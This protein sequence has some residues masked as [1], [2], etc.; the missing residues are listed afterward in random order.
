MKGNQNGLEIESILMEL[1]V[2]L[3]EMILEKCM[4]SQ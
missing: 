4:E 3:A 2:I 1:V